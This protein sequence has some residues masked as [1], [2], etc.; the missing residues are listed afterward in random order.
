[1][2]KYF[3]AISFPIKLGAALS[4]ALP[5]AALAFLSPHSFWSTP[6]DETKATL[7][8]ASQCINDAH[9]QASL[10]DT[11]LMTSSIIIDCKN[12]LDHEST[13][14]K[15]SF[16]AAT[17]RSQITHFDFSTPQTQ[18][19]TT[20]PWADHHS[21]LLDQKLSHGERISIG[22]CGLPPQS[23]AMKPPFRD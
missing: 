17:R 11:C 8:T 19:L 12:S 2:V 22:W 20:I 1:M 5:L 10:P 13:I 18:K 14:S 4:L 6:H 3:S 21:L 16:V 7:T 15:D 9:N 23:G